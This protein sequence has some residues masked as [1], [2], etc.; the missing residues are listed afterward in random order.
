MGTLSVSVPDIVLYVVDTVVDGGGEEISVKI[1]GV[2]AF[3]I[4]LFFHTVSGDK[5][6]SVA[7]YNASNE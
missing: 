2:V 4:S 3:D 1:R 7:N 5:A 6:A